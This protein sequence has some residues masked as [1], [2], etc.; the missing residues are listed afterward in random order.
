MD[1]TVITQGSPTVRVS[2]FVKRYKKQV[3]VQGVDLEINR[4]EI[5]GLI[6]PDGAGKSSLM[7]AIA[8]VLSYEGGA[9]EVF[10]TTVD[11]ER[12]AEQIKQ[13]I[14]FLP[15]GLGLNLYPDLSVEENIDFFARIR[16]VPEHELDQRKARFLAMTRLEKF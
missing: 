4:G 12:S 2:Q 8:G 14:G 6:G 15:Q 1:E 5:Y 13:K 3:A 10:G 9:V 7:K 11:S 16:L